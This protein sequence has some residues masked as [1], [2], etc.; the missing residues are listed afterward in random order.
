VSVAASQTQAEQPLVSIGLPVYN[1][2]DF[3]AKAIDSLLGQTYRGIELV[4]SDNASNDGSSELCAAVAARD[5]RVKYSRLADNIGGVN[6]HNRVRE[7]ARGSF[8][9]FGSSDDIWQPTYVERCAEILIADPRVAVAYTLNSLMD[10]HGAPKGQV[11]P[12]YALDTDDVTNR[13]RQLVQTDSPI[14][15]FYGLIRKTALDAT[16]K[17]ILHPGFDRFM[18]LELGLLGRFRQVP[19][20]LYVRRL[21][22]NQSVNAYRSLRQRYRWV[23]PAARNRRFVWPYWEYAA[24]FARV[25]IRSAPDLRTKG[26]CLW[27]VLKWC[28]WEKDELWNDLIGA[29]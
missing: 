15:P 21:H 12:F 22:S 13:F 6:N 19:E 26:R 29:Q 27:H 3:L 14:E 25:A 11:K 4:I 5:P 2:G 24:N 23:S 16:A 1:G 8:F 20:P 10:E 7:L 28:N 9:M 17:L 18:L